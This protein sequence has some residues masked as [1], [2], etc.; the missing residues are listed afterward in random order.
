MALS[1]PHQLREWL[2][3]VDYP[4]GKDRLVAAAQAGGAPQELVAALRTIPP[5]E[6]ANRSEVAAAVPVAEGQS[7]SEKA[8]EDRAPNQSGLAEGAREVSTNPIVEELGEN[9]G[10]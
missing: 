1:D 7:D 5:V 3:D 2:G 10:S 6:Y 8:K 4:A 9:R